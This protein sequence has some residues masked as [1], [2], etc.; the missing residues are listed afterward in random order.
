VSHLLPSESILQEAH[1]FKSQLFDLTLPVL[2]IS[3]LSTLRFM[4]VL[5]P[6]AEALQALEIVHLY[7]NN[8]ITITL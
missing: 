1:L 8:A 3:F 2:T 4:L 5:D 7:H 6:M